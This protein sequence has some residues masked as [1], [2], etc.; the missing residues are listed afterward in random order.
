MALKWNKQN[1]PTI[2]EKKISELSNIC[3]TT[4]QAGIDVEF[5][6][7][8]T[9]HFSLDTADQLN[10]NSMFTAITLGAT[11]YPYHADN[12]PCELY[13][14]EDIIRIYAV[15]KTFVTHQ[16]TYFNCLKAWVD[17]EEDNNEIVKITYGAAL[18]ADLQEQFESIMASANIQIKALA[19]QLGLANL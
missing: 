14:A 5:T 18:P 3:E 2:A 8:T 13:K 15:Y 1:L 12:E 7:G 4:I 16:T 17:R 10:L 11:E 6:D 9:K 19:G